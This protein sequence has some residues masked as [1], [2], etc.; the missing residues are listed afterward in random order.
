MLGFAATGAIV[1]SAAPQERHAAVLEMHLDGSA[2][3]LKRMSSE[4]DALDAH[5]ASSSNPH[6]DP[7]PKGEG[8]RSWRARDAFELD[9]R[10]REIEVNLDALVLEL[11]RH[12]IGL[13][14]QRRVE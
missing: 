1:L 5:W 10:A 9:Q 6:P 12:S 4:F 7:L 8:V 2:S 14:Q 13:Q 11:D 3:T